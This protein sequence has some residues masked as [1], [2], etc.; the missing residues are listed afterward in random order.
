VT[1][2]ERE[3]VVDGIRMRWQERGEGVPVVLIHGIPTSPR[4][5]RHVLPRIGAG[6][7]LAWEMVG[8]GRSI[9]EG[10]GRDISVRRQ[11]EYLLRWMRELGVDAAVLVGHDLGGGVAQIAAVHRPDACLGLVLV[12]SIS[13]DSWPIA[14]VRA[15]RAAGEAVRRLP[16]V[17]MGP[18]FRALVR[19]GH[20]APGLGD[21]SARA[22]WEPYAGRGAGE[23]F[24]R[25]ADALRTADTLEVGGRLGEI[26]VPTRVV[27]GGRDPF[28]P[29]AYGER[30]AR[31][32]DA[33]LVRIDGGR[34]FTPEDHPDV[35]AGAIGEV[36]DAAATRAVA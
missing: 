20:D 25:Q 21:R 17:A 23:A 35:V 10:E 27:W 36:V 30:L 19:L 26:R 32:L 15:M 29:V 14:P 6:R 11:A 33:P 5:W 4:L 28:Q 16:D 9:S 13:H 12:D 24:V 22:H 34:H 31:E 8:Y 1:A 3:A 7:C 18:M 2:P